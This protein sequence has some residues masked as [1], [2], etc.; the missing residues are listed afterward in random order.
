MI[1]GG[2][3]L[4]PRSFD[5][6]SISKQPPHVREIWG[7]ILQ[8]A[9]HKDSN[10]LKRGQLFTSYSE[11]IEALSWYVGF[12]KE[13]YKKHQCETAMKVLMKQNMITTTRT[14][15]GVIVTVCNYDYYQDPKNY[16]SH[17]EAKTRTT[18]EPHENRT[19]N[20]NVNKEEEEK[21]I[22]EFNSICYS[23]PKVERVTTARK[24]KIKSRLAEFKKNEV[25]YIEL[26]RKVEE[27]DFLTGRSSK[28]K[29]TFDWLFENS[30]NWVKVYENNYLNNKNVTVNST[31]Q[32]KPIFERKGSYKDR[33]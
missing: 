24:N 14:T 6:G 12:R 16:E 31:Q 32:Q 3:I 8:N 13:S 26:F 4:Q 2:Y 17:N 23:L 21:I 9:N 22:K 29:A 19:I 27:S 11:I 25:D 20:K 15:R 5:T 10:N 18:R 30:E 7:Y 28:W 33:F 1:N